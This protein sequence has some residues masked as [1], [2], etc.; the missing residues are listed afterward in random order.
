MVHWRRT[1]E[2]TLL[3][4]VLLLATQKALAS[5]EAFACGP[6]GSQ[7]KVDTEDHWSVHSKHVVPHSI[8]VLV[9]SS[10]GCGI[11][12]PGAFLSRWPWEH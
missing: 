8:K 4:P 10:S 6:K 3:G 12:V 2:D 11:C 5:I 9:S 7:S 1:T